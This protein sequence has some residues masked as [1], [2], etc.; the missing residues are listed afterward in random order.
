MKNHASVC[1]DEGWSDQL[2]VLSPPSVAIEAGS[3]ALD[4]M[5]LITIVGLH[6]VISVSVTLT[7]Y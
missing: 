1:N 2:S 7:F 5:L 3:F 6:L 4:M